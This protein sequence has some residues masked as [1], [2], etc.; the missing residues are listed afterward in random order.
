VGANRCGVEPGEPALALARLVAGQPGLRF[1][2]LQAYQGR[3]QHIQDLEK[4]REAID[5]AVEK[6]RATL[7]LL[8]RDGLRCEMVTGAGTGS[9]RFEAA[10]GVYTELQAGSYVFMDVDY[11]RV[12]GFPSEFENA[13]FVLATV[14][15][16]PTPDRAVIDAGLKAFSVHSGMPAVRGMSDVESAAPPTTRRPLVR[17]PGARLGLG[18]TLAD[19]RPLRPDGQ[20]LRL[21][22]RD[23]GAW[24]RRSGSITA[25][26]RSCDGRHPR[27]L[28]WCRASR[29]PTRGRPRSARAPARRR[30]ACGGL[31]APARPASPTWRGSSPSTC[32][33]TARRAA[34]AATQHRQVRRVGARPARRARARSRRPRRPLDDGGRRADLASPPGLPARPRPGGDR[35]PAP[36]LPRSSSC[37]VKARPGAELVASLAY[38]RGRRLGAS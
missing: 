23:R 15:S 24:S 3:A 21:V 16:R 27:P 29:P 35:R 6:V 13:L 12:Q 30:R 8:E 32:P 10:S 11:K 34:A 4:R 20:P 36:V 5:L 28:R 14:M 9:Y 33:A 38:S 2:G 37:S 1:A 31:D 17:D 22:R 18:E 25:R 26:G 19:S 7:E